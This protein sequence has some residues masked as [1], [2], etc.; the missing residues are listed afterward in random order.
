MKDNFFNEEELKIVNNHL[1]KYPHKMAATLPV[2]WMIQDKYGWISKDA[3][4]Y[5]AGLL[6]VPPDHVYGVVTFYTMYNEKPVGKVHLQIC[7]NVSCML[8]GA[9]DIFHYISDKLKIKNKETTT[10]GIF[11]IEE[12]ECLGSCGTAPMMQVNNREY[13]ENLSLDKIDTLLDELKSKHI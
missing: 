4:R 10:D 11:T 7:T 2:L 1:K 8:N 6:D 9:Y 12:V 5:V 13:H 3:M